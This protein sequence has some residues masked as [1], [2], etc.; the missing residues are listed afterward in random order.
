MKKTHTMY[1]IEITKPHSK[2]MYAHNDMVADE[3]KNNIIKAWEAEVN[4][5]NMDD[6]WPTGSIIDNIIDIQSSICAVGYGY[7]YTI[8]Q[9]ND[10]FLKELDTMANWKLHEEYSYLCSKELVPRTGF[11]MVGFE[12]PHYVYDGRFASNGEMVSFAK[13]MYLE[14]GFQYKADAYKAVNKMLRKNK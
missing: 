13:E 1:G 5:F 11:M 4:K 9:V 7:G 10:D 6:E 12:Q 2:E 8:K 3:M 14:N